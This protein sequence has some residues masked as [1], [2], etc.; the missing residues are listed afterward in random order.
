MTDSWFLYELIG[1]ASVAQRGLI[2]KAGEVRS[3]LKLMLGNLGSRANLVTNQLCDLGQVP[4]SLGAL[5]FFT[6]FSKLAVWVHCV[7]SLSLFSR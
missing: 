2:E 7:Y 5:D 1:R 4:G 6:Q 3:G